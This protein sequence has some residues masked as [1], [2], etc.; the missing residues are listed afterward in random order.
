[1]TREQAHQQLQT[2]LQDGQGQLV[3]FFLAQVPPPLW[4]FFLLGPFAV[5]AL[6]HYHVGVTSE[7]L[8]FQQLTM[9]GK[10]GQ[11]DFFRFDEI[12]DVKIGT[13][14][15]LQ[16]RV[17]FNFA[18]GTTLKMKAQLKGV[19]KVPKLTPELQGILEQ[20]IAIAS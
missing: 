5:F 18:N 19:E 1:M 9:M 4:M 12:R 7:G 15:L 2:D 16:R 17:R 3:G 14:G 10:H 6:K 11:R 13:G 20:R 8:V